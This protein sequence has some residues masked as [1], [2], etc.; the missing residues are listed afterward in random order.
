LGL[1]RK[2][3]NYIDLLVDVQ[4]HQM[5]VNGIFNG[6]PHP[7]NLLALTDGTL[8]LVDYGQTKT[9]SKD[10]RLGVAR[11]VYAL[12]SGSNNNQIAEAMRQLG[13]RTKFDQDDTLAKYA[14]LFFD[15][16]TEGKKIGCATPQMYFATLTKL[17]PLVNVPDVA[18][19]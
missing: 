13:F 15:S 11:I 1:Y 5:L 9:I 4:G 10:E 16:D 12:G 3:K 8:G 2:T 7:G 6:D 14:A 19:K 18:S 17:D